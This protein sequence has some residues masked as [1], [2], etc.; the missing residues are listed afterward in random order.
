MAAAR[1]LTPARAVAGGGVDVELSRLGAL[2]PVSRAGGQG[3]V[4]APSEG[5][6]LSSVPLVV[7]L[8]R[9]TRGPGCGARIGEMVAW[10]RG[11]AAEER[12]RLYRSCAWPLASVS[13]DGAF[14]GI[15]MQDLRERF[16]LPFVMPS[17]RVSPVML[18]LEH[19]L[20]PDDYLQQ[21]GRPQRLDTRLRAAIAERIAAAFAFLHARDVV[22]SDVSPSN[23]L[24]ALAG[25]GPEVALID[26]DSMVFRGRQALP[27][28][29]TA[30][31]Q[32]PA[33]FGEQPLTR[34][35]DGYKLGLIVLRV[36]ARASDARGLED[37]RAHVPA[38]LHG[39]L[40]R[41]LSPAPASRPAAREWELALRG[42]RADEHLARRHPGPRPPLRSPARRASR[43]APGGY[44][45]WRPRAGPPGATAA[46]RP[47]RARGRTGARAGGLEGGSW[48]VFTAAWL[49]AGILTLVLF[50]RLLESAAT[51]TRVNAGTESRVRQ[52]EYLVLGPDRE[53]RRAEPAQGEAGA[54]G[55]AGAGER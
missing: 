26:C 24:I 18:A 46:A 48:S 32:I 36:F 29:Q 7:K 45:A 50:F 22:V 6:R 41:A 19:V 49:V 2:T 11:L 34:A 37:H 20:G 55:E 27:S 44:G 54:A 14:A 35:A 10:G 38:Q 47:L 15:L 31:W 12:R 25:A 40:E 21:R 8:Y 43:E 52:G 23:L 3:R 17:G 51:P 30:D 42:V 13:S 4:Y 16:E 1:V 33:S 5:P 39:M 28:V 53:A 9:T